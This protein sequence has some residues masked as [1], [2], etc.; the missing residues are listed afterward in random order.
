M[1]F[2]DERDLKSLNILVLTRW[3]NS[4]LHEFVLLVADW[5]TEEENVRL[6]LVTHVVNPTL[7]KKSNIKLDFLYVKNCFS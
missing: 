2:I 6:R 4:R 5:A 1:P 7:K 3:A